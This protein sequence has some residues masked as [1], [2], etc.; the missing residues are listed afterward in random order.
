MEGEKNSFVLVSSDTSFARRISSTLGVTPTTV[1]DIGHL[2]GITC[3]L[4]RE[5]RSGETLVVVDD[6]L[7]GFSQSHVMQVMEK[8]GFTGEVLYLSDNPIG[9]R[10]SFSETANGP[11]FI[12]R[13]SDPGSLRELIGERLKSLKR[14]KDIRD[15]ASDLIAGESPAVKKLREEL[16]LYAKGKLNILLSG[17][18]G[19]GKELAALAIHRLSGRSG[20][21][22]TVNSA[23]LRGS[24][25]QDAVFGH[26][27]GAFTGALTEKKGIL[28]LADKGTLFLD[29]I[30]Y[31]GADSGAEF[32]RVLERKS[33]R[34]LGGTTLREVDV[35]LVTA[36]SGGDEPNAKTFPLGLPLYMR[37]AQKVI[38]IPP[39]RERT[40]DIEILAANFLRSQG[41]KRRLSRESLE[42]ARSYSWPGNVRQ[43]FNVLARASTES[44]GKRLISINEK[45]FCE[46]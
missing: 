36:Y 3:N 21:Y 23:S 25:F 20:D 46:F 29:E 35:R 31:L 2:L 45:E 43:L 30:Q 26:K 39:L 19:S 8:S 28:E 14:G 44:V 11:R 34:A 37:L 16:R 24:L 9:I 17:E 32:L 22:I 7:D 5:N 10:F 1:S 15:I 12:P 42:R 13:P 6:R 4:E 33:F 38:R 40:E 27:K 41:E 18:S